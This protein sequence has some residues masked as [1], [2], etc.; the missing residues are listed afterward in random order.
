M[1]GKMTESEFFT[2]LQQKVRETGEIGDV[3]P[4]MVEWNVPRFLLSHL[5]PDVLSQSP[6]QKI[7]GLPLFCYAAS[8]TGWNQR[9]Q[10]IKSRAEKNGDGSFTLHLNKAYVMQAETILLLLR[11]AD[12]FCLAM[13]PFSD[14]QKR[15]TLMER[16]EPHTVFNA[17]N[18]NAVLHYRL[19]GTATVDSGRV[20]SIKERAYSLYGVQIPAREIIGLALLA[21]ALADHHSFHAIEDRRHWFREGETQL[22]AARDNRRLQKHDISLAIELIEA[23]AKSPIQKHAIWEQWTSLAALWKR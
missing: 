22:F 15:F 20:H 7:T 2:A 3:F 13:I 12:D 6:T 16:D 14:A 9:I 5:W 23:F 19:S 21:V 4:C 1:E 11:L 18:G 17:S 8:E 10:N